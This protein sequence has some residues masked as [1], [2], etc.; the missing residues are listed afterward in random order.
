MDVVL[1]KGLKAGLGYRDGIGSIFQIGNG[2][3][4][5]LIGLGVLGD[6]S[7]SV[8]HRDV[9]IGDCGSGRIQRGPG[10]RPGS[11]LGI[12]CGG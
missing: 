6:V 5:G 2:E 3:E 10:N 7:P 1:S 4:T 9:R 8:G 12:S 11:D